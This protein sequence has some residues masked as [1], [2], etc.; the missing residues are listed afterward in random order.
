LSP[1]FS[2]ARLT[3]FPLSIPSHIRSHAFLFLIHRYLEQPELALSDFDNRSAK[4]ANTFTLKR[5]DISYENIDTEAELEFAREMK[6]H[7]EE[8]CKTEMRGVEG[9]EA[10]GRASEADGKERN[11]LA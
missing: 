11:S 10:D 6:L 9:T 3:S 2:E 5:G 8:F 1:Y 4:L 7:R